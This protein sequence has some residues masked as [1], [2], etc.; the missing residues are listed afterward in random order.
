MILCDVSVVLSAG[1]PESPHHRVC[2][3]RVGELVDGG[4]PFA[5]SDLVLASVV[6]IATN[7][8]V[9]K[10][11]ASPSR[12]FAFV[13]SLR[14]HPDAVIVAPGPRHWRLFQELATVSGARGADLTDAYLAA[15][16]V[17]HGCEWWTADAD[18]ARF[19][20][21]RWRNVLTQ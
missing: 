6:R 5:L 10:K 11:P 12:A 7:A 19:P 20:G 8:R 13:D 3:E 15:L 18:F 17:E 2:K 21:L 16:A 14:E 4:V 9:W 1:M